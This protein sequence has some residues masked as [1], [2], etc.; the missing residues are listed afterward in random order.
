MFPGKCGQ[1]STLDSARSSVDRT[2]T[3][4]RNARGAPNP[5]SWPWW[6]TVA[7]RRITVARRR[8]LVAGWVVAGRWRLVSRSRL[9][10]RRRGR[11]RGRSLLFLLSLVGARRVPSG[12][13]SASRWDGCGRCGLQSVS[14][15]A[16]CRGGRGRLRRRLLCP[17]RV[18]HAEADANCAEHDGAARAGQAEQRHEGD[19]P[20]HYGRITRPACGCQRDGPRRAA[21]R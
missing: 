15:R 11:R 13:R 21:V 10:G 1:V 17:R 20:D 9:W 4:Q 7:R 6:I 5:A 19:A 2:T 16:R 12:V 8:R 18:A 14:R 3:S